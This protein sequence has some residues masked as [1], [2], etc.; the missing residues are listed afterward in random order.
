MGCASSI[1]GVWRFRPRP[2]NK[3]GVHVRLTSD[4]AQARTDQIPNIAISERG[5]HVDLG[6]LIGELSSIRSAFMWGI[7]TPDDATESQKVTR[8]VLQ[9]GTPITEINIF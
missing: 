7:R 4:N 5:G 1:L 8:P 3:C 9:G 6:W 2:A